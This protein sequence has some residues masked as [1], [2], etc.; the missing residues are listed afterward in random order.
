MAVHPCG[1]FFVVGYVD[2][3][4]AFWA[5]EDEDRPLLVRTLDSI[6]VNLAHG[7]ELESHLGGSTSENPVKLE[8]EPIFKLSWSGYPDTSSDTAHGHTTLTILG[9]MLGSDWSG[10]SVYQFSGFDTSNV[11]LTTEVT[12]ETPLPTV[13]RTVMRNS[14]NPTET[15]FY[16]TNG[17]AQDYLLI[18]KSNPHFSGVYD[19][20]A[21]LIS[22]EPRANRRIVEAFQ[23]PPPLFVDVAQDAIRAPA[24]PDDLDDIT[25]TLR[26]LQ[27]S[28]DAQVLRLPL[29]LWNP[30]TGLID[31]QLKTVDNETYDVFV[32]NKVPLDQ[33]LPLKGGVAWSDETQL[34]ELKLS[35]VWKLA[36][37]RL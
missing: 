32:R 26:D 27:L 11:P 29:T 37:E 25:A 14:L 19:P 24:P 30:S 7:L 6:D 10:V 31:G 1:H 2:G 18:P 12:Q 28:N 16:Q 23:F 5:V 20:V 17:L 35:K 3:C 21:I 9:G 4:F 15:Y 34:N 13:I 36:P 22:Y 33:S 8:R